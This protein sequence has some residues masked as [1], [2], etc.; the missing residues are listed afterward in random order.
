MN[1]TTGST[2]NN[3]PYQAPH[4]AVG[5]LP[6][7]TDAGALI[8]GG[9]AVAAGNAMHWLGAGWSLFTKSVGIWIVNMI[10]LLI[11]SFVLAFIP[12][13]GGLISSLISPVL[14]GGLMLG[15][16]ALHNGHPLEVGHLFAGFKDKAGQLMLVGLLML[17]AYFAIVIVLAIVAV[18]VIGAGVFQAMGA[19]G[20]DP[21]AFFA[22][23]GLVAILLIVLLALAL[24]IPLLMAYWFAPAL[25]V[26]H[27]L[28]AIPAMKQSF[29]ACL[30]NLLPFLLYGLVALVLVI[31][32]MIPLFLGLF[33]V[34]PMLYGS[35]YASYRDI[36]LNA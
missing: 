16:H 31:I 14:F 15:C 33:A 13:I 3:N 18:V 5:G 12:F 6:P 4:S 21:S 17:V 36:F 34:I 9:R 30:R 25:I 19:E 7:M 29:S 23:G 20:F 26:L 22:A 24:M 1:P 8:D 27:D 35:I 2:G 32:G 10:V 11:I 28:E